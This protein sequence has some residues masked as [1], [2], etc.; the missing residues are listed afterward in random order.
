MSSA[1]ASTS[2]ERTASARAARAAEA[3]W[4]TSEH[5]EPLR[6]PAADGP[7]QLEGSG[8][9]DDGGTAG[10]GLGRGDGMD[11]IEGIALVRN[12]RGAARSHPH[13]AHLR[14]RQQHEVR[15][16]GGDEGAHASHGAD[17][18]GHGPA[19]GLPGHRR[20]LQL[21]PVRQ[22]RGDRLAIGLQAGAR[23]QRPGQLQGQVGPQRSQQL[24]TLGHGP[25]P[26]GDQRA[27]GDGSRLLQ[28][29]APGHG[30][31]PLGG[32]HLRQPRPDGVHDPG[33]LGEAITDLQ[34]GGRV[35]D[36][37]G[38]GTTV[39]RLSVIGIEPLAQDRQQRDERRA[40]D[41]AITQDPAE[42]SIG[43]S[44]TATTASAAA[45]LCVPTSA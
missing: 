18:R 40:R 22:C 24:Q 31:V 5:G 35:H 42:S 20:P 16:H 7:L 9:A 45:T 1:R 17:D 27:E 8:V 14:L 21:E 26:A 33:Q 38:G 29:R 41:P 34:H 36:V 25:E 15:G 11:G 3:V 43:A 32:C 12:D 30:C 44:Q 13:L 37:L 39:E 28:E 6:V 2:S 10:T 4:N 19:V 23:P